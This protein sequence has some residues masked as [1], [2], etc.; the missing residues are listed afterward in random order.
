V[1]STTRKRRASLKFTEIKT[2]VWLCPEGYRITRMPSNEFR[3]ERYQVTRRGKFL[4]Q[5]VLI[6]DA[7]EQCEFLEGAE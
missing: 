7:K 1:H 5:H 3:T 4:G 6:E 2:G